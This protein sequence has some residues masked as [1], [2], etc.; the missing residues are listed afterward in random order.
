MRANKKRGGKKGSPVA[1]NGRSKGDGAHVRF[2]R[3]E[4]ESPAYRSLSAFA[5][6]LLVELKGLHNGSNNGE[7]FLSVREAAARLNC[8]RMTAD[9]ALHDLV[10]RGFIRARQN[11]SFSWKQR[12]ATQW[13]L[14]E[15]PFAGALPTK[16]FMLWQPDEKQNTGLPQGQTGLPQGQKAT[17]TGLK[18]AIWPTTGTVK[19]ES[20]AD[21]SLR[22]YTDK[23]PEGSGE[24]GEAA[25][26]NPSIGRVI[27][28]RANGH[29]IASP[30]HII[31]DP[32]QIDPE[33]AIAAKAAGRKP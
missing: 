2:Y 18:Q 8:S 27:P 24:C 9:R 1:A 21:L 17:T 4:L 22:Q 6:A 7:L 3:F 13:V 16:D 33:E 5:R 20:V 19:A 15:F 14:A 28:L 11:G 32:N 26:S 25:S 29:A 23:L 12:H 31:H 10:D 30:C